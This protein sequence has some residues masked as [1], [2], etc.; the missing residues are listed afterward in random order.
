MR[1]K[2]GPQQKEQ[3]AKDQHEDYVEEPESGP[4]DA[5]VV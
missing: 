5:Y 1:Y 2:A 4:V 3:R